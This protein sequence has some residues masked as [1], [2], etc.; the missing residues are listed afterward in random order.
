MW[1]RWKSGLRQASLNRRRQPHRSLTNFVFH[2][3]FCRCISLV[4]LLS[5][6][7]R[8]VPCICIRCS[9]IIWHMKILVFVSCHYFI[10]GFFFHLLFFLFRSFFDRTIWIICVHIEATETLVVRFFSSRRPT[11]R[12]K[13][14]RCQNKMTVASHAHTRALTR[15]NTETQTHNLR[16]KTI[17]LFSSRSLQLPTYRQLFHSVNIETRCHAEKRCVRM[18]S[19]T[20]RVFDA[21]HLSQSLFVRLKIS[22]L[23]IVVLQKP[24]SVCWLVVETNTTTEHL[25]R[26]AS[27]VRAQRWQL[28]VPLRSQHR[29]RFDAV[30]HDRSSVLFI[31]TL[32]VTIYPHSQTMS[33]SI[34]SFIAIERRAQE[35]AKR[36]EIDMNVCVNE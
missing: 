17:N 31:V 35:R 25:L 10:D 28:H 19:L 12:Q 33:A 26:S 23:R 20:L 29:L 21:A 36:Y 8:L 18:H 2:F 15:P 34:D 14:F 9:Y 4:L 3:V 11:Q 7:P 27:F 32:H 30:A 16:I 5:R 1:F 22:C 13:S 24:I 6:R